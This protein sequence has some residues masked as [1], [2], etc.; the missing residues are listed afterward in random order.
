MMESSRGGSVCPGRFRRL[1]TSKSLRPSAWLVLVAAFVSLST[2]AAAQSF[3][4]AAGDQG[5]P[6]G[7]AV[8]PAAGQIYDANNG[9]ASVTV[10]SGASENVVATIPVGTTPSAIAVDALTNTI[11]VANSGSG[12]VSV[13]SGAT[14]TVIATVT[15][16]TT[17]SAM[18]V[19]PLAS[20][21]YVAN[22]GTNNLSVIPEATNA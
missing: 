5:A 17:P 19:D 10:F 7:G 9:S 22:S 13:I 4:V 20:I 15:V 2:R 3:T 16:G 11:Y 1:L 12:N 6:G 21:V 8:H 18:A 14:N